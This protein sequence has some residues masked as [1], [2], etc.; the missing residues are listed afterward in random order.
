MSVIPLG[1]EI[2]LEKLK[3]YDPT[4]PIELLQKLNEQANW[5]I[6]TKDF[7][8]FGY[9]LYSDKTFSDEKGYELYMD[10]NDFVKIHRPKNGVFICFAHVQKEEIENVRNQ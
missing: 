4:N 2:N 1:G 3:A 8:I 10:N 5:M 9:K 6:K 7:F